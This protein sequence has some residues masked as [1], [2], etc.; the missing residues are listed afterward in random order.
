M[1]NPELNNIDN[2]KNGMPSDSGDLGRRPDTDNTEKGT[3]NENKKQNKAC[4]GEAVTE[5]ARSEKDREADEI[6]HKAQKS[7]E[8]QKS[9]K[10]QI[11]NNTRD[12]STYAFRWDFDSQIAD[13]KKRA[14]RSHRIDAVIYTTIVALVFV[15]C[16]IAA[17]LTGNGKNNDQ[18][19]DSFAVTESL[20]P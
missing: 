2:N 13:R 5:A 6:L 18:P 7:Q 9:Q 16:I 14:K 8:S 17:V 15:F 1:D 12:E 20:Q 4:G 3:A 11:E 10:S 19:D